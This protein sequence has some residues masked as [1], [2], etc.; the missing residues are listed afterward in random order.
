MS[1]DNLLQS[2]PTAAAAKPGTSP[3]A[4]AAGKIPAPPAA[5]PAPGTAKKEKEEE[6]KMTPKPLRKTMNTVRV[7]R[8]VGILLS[9]IKLL[10]LLQQPIS[11]QSGPMKMPDAKIEVREGRKYILHFHPIS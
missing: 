7:N 3:A 11:L 2:L 8:E 5:P 6:K 4:P 9:L 1:L 10:F